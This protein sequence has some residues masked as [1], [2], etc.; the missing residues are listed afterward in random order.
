[1]LVMMTFAS[2][3]AVVMWTSILVFGKPTVKLVPDSPPGYFDHHE[4]PP[5]TNEQIADEAE[6]A[7]VRTMNIAAARVFRLDED[8]TQP[9]PYGE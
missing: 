8:I 9:S 7:K 5:K 3:S 1:M 4:P 2:I 6:R